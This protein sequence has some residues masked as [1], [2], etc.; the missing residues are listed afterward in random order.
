[1]DRGYVSGESLTASDLGFAVIEIMRRHAP[2]VVST[3]LTRAVEERLE[4]IESGTEREKNLIRETVRAISDQLVALSENEA[5]V[6]RDLKSADKATVAADAIG[7]CPVCKTGRLRIIRSK[8]TGKR[9]VGCTNYA[10][11][12]RASAPLPQR[13]ILKSTGKVCKT[14]AWPVIYVRTGRFPWKLCVNAKCPAKAS[15]RNE[16]QTV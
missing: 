15:R 11:G 14:C 1:V 10:K 8:K 16:V 7:A 5:A 2:S 13:G 12:C 4:R 6:G 3:D 9:F